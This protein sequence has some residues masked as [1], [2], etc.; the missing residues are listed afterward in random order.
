M[1]RSIANADRGRH[2][3][4]SAAVMAQE[5]ETLAQ[6]ANLFPREP[7][8]SEL[9]PAQN[10]L[11]CLLIAALAACLTPA[12]VTAQSSPS[13]S[14][15]ALAAPSGYSQPPKNILEV[16]H[17]PSPPAPNVSPT[18]DAI[19]LVSWQDYPPISRVATPFLRLAGARV[20]PRNHSKHDTPGGYGITPCARSFDLVRLDTGVQI[21]IV[22]PEGA[23]PGQPVW[24]ADGK[25]FA[26][27]NLDTDAVEL[28]IGDG[29]T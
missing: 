3:S 4:G 15:A 20:E 9:M 2:R 8:Q 23:C 13:L 27:V 28:W 17:A 16:M 11:S 21:H 26:F 12:P 6:V 24:S 25:R 1:N 18:G 22:L 10:T 7:N 29:K 19:L 14:V 5:S